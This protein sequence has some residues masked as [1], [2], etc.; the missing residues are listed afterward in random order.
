MTADK[1]T[2]NNAVYD[3]GDPNLSVVQSETPDATYTSCIG[4]P[5]WD[6]DPTLHTKLEAAGWRYAAIIGIVDPE[7][8]EQSGTID[9]DRQTYAHLVHTAADGSPCWHCRE[10]TTFVCEQAGVSR[11]VAAAWLNLDWVGGGE[12]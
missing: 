6:H 1:Q 4:D 5:P 11:Q 2:T 3:V 12:V 10:A 8:T 7:E 9:A